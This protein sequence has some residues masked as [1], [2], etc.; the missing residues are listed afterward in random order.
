M[1]TYEFMC[2]QC[3]ARGEVFT[4]SITSGVKPPACPKGATATGHEMR[5]IVS[6]FTRHLTTAD[7]LAEA[8][9]KYGKEVDAAMG[10]EPDIGKYARRY[11]S[12]SKGLPT[13]R[14]L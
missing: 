9:A 8:E 2:A 10:P 3:G 5:R 13:D 4:R 11:E 1:P 6:R 14:D 12:L 7:Q